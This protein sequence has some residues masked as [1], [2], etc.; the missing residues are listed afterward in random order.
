MDINKR[1]TRMQIIQTC[2]V[3]VLSITLFFFAGC[4]KQLTSDLQGSFPLDYIQ[5]SK[6]CNERSFKKVAITGVKN[7][8]ELAD[9]T[10]ASLRYVVPIPLLF[11]NIGVSGYMCKLG[12]AAF[13]TKIEN[14]VLESFKKEAQ[15]S[16]CFQIV[17][18]GTEDYTVDLTIVDQETKGPYSKYFYLYFAVYAY[19]Y[20][21]GQSAGP[22]ESSV[23]MN[24][25][26]KGKNGTSI[27]RQF[28]SQ[29]KTEILKGKN[30][31]KELR[32]NYVVGMVESASFAYKECIENAITAINQHMNGT[33]INVGRVAPVEQS[34]DI[35]VTQ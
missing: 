3:V 27:N 10:Y 22:G 25:N 34:R 5:D 35:E 13:D 29:K 28:E 1:G 7:T 24:M 30:D 11:I 19:G 17:D 33:E 26:L 4:A 2:L 20:G 18:D 21:F 16:G 23:V 31:A 14:F 9:S 12:Q 8:V 6:Q 15:R 32:K